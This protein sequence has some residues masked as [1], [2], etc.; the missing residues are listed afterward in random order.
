MVIKPIPDETTG[1]VTNHIDLLTD[2]PTN[3]VEE[4]GKIHASAILALRDSGVNGFPCS[5]RFGEK[6]TQEV[7]RVSN[8]KG[9]EEGEEQYRG[10]LSTR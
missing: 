8:I 4:I 6:T 1:I 5:D 9:V 2:I 7:D 3:N 10:T